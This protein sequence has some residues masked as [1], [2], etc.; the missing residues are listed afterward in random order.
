M[1]RAILPLTVGI[2][3]ATISWTQINSG[4]ITGLA[5]DK[6]GAIIPGAA[7]SAVNEDTRVAQKTAT[8]R[9]GE[10]AVPYLA[11][12][13]YTVIVEKSGFSAFK[14]T[15]ILV[16]TG[17]QVRV[18]AHLQVGSVGTI[19]EVQAEALAI[20][21][22]S[23]SV[24]GRIDSRV[25]ESVPDLNHN[26][27]YFATL[28]AGIVAR[29]ELTNSTDAYSFGVGIYARDKCPRFPSTAPAPSPA[30]SRWTA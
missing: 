30:T 27:F 13:R 9:S 22:E 1:I 7:V 5:L 16:G 29:N 15:G 26:P 19:V 2:L 14:Q 17:E 23:T 28:E 12:G 4:T 8:D 21:T 6:T 25:I 11:A 18:D 3:T 24:Q 10:Y 20:Q